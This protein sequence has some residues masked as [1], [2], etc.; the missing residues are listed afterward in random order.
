MASS[1][2]GVFSTI[3]SLTVS[4]TRQNAGLLN[5]STCDHRNPSEKMPS[6]GSENARRRRISAS[7]RISFPLR[8]GL[9]LQIC[10]H[11][12]LSGINSGLLYSSVIAIIDRND[13]D[14]QFVKFRC[15]AA[16]TAT[17]TAAAATTA[18]A[19]ATATA[20]AA[21]AATAIA[22]AGA[23]SAALPQQE[24]ST[25]DD[26][27]TRTRTRMRTD[28]RPYRAPSPPFYGHTS[29]LAYRV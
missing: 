19:T 9:K 6:H 27:L 18:A 17:A 8:R 28:A 25:S 14:N 10:V 11:C 16:A 5:N 2:A 26:S 1:V 15:A 7:S 21:A 22:G 12:L 29:L 4:A 13:R 20:A 3:Q 24:Q 23:T